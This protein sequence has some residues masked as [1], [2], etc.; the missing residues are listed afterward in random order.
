ME[1]NP[2]LKN[3]L[4]FAKG[5]YMR[6]KGTPLVKHNM[7]QE[8]IWILTTQFGKLEEDEWIFDKNDDE[9]EEDDDCDGN[10]LD[11][12]MSI[13]NNRCICSHVITKVFSITH[14]PTSISFQ[15]GSDC[16]KK[17]LPK[18]FLE[19]KLR[20]RQRAQEIADEEKTRKLMNTYTM[21]FGKYINQPITNLPLDYVTWIYSK[22]QEDHNAF[23]K[24]RNFRRVFDLMFNE[25]YAVEDES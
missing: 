13:D 4:Y 7:K 3:I 17:N 22:I 1:L 10:Y 2:K 8:F 5:I 9:H 19:Y 18:I 25:D 23:N 21:H 15:V 11:V 14:R 16:I 24:H 20:E 6:G 12:N